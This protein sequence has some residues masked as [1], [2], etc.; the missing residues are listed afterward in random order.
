MSD[1]EFT[2]AD[3]AAMTLAIEQARAD[4]PG[5]AAQINSKLADEPFENVGWFA[6]AVCQRQMLGLK[7]W[8]LPPCEIFDSDGEDVAARRL[9]RRMLKAKISRFH[10]NP[11]KALAEAKRSKGR[12]DA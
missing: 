10:P 1:D 9:L 12:R 3:V 4:D 5:R 2:E 6:A 11:R 7:P 8:E